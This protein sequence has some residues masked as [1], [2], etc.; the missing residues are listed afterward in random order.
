M[1]LR[2]GA[3]SRRVDFLNNPK[4]TPLINKAKEDIRKYWNANV[5]KHFHAAEDHRSFA[6]ATSEKFGGQSRTGQLEQACGVSFVNG[7]FTVSLKSIMDKDG[8][9]DYGDFLF[10]GTQS[11]RGAY[12]PEI[13]ARIRDK[14]TGELIGFTQ[15]ISNAPWNRWVV[16]LNE[17]VERRLSQLEDEIYASSSIDDIDGGSDANQRRV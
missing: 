10:Y 8:K 2:T 4:F 17:Y 9:R 16:E 6:L 13:G 1:S 14:K 5:G 15:G 7:T 11:T 3:K 12:S